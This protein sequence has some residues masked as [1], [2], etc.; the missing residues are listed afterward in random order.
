VY[1]NNVDWAG[2]IVD[3]DIEFYFTIGESN[4]IYISGNMVRLDEN[5]LQSIDKLQKYYEKFKSKWAKVI[6]SRKKTKPTE[7]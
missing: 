6:A 3:F 2:K 5:F 7:E 1:S 4:G